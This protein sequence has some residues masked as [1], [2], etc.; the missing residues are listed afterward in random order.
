MMTSS[1]D[2]ETSNLYIGDVFIPGVAAMT[3][4]SNADVQADLRR[5]R[6]SSSWKGMLAALVA[7]PMFAI[8]INRLSQADLQPTERTV[9]LVLPLL[10]V[11]WA[12]REQ[13]ASR[14]KW[15]EFER[16][17]NARA[18]EIAYPLTLGWMLLVALVSTAFGFPV[19]I[20]MPFGLPPVQLGWLGILLV[21]L[22]LPA[23]VFV[24]VNKRYF[25][26]R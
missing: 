19:S 20:A 18:L 11:G 7:G 24:L 14:R 4:I 17:L 6:R 13:L 8:A 21:P 1:L 9:W 16:M 5:L 10:A 23:V 26:K 12:I 25:D 3:K 15:D 22:M 2:I